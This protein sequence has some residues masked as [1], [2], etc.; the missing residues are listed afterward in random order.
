[1]VLMESKFCPRCGYNFT[2]T[3]PRKKKLVVKLHNK[4]CKGE[5]MSVEEQLSL[6]LDN[7]TS[8]IFNSKDY[9]EIVMAGEND[10]IKDVLDKR[11]K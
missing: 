7:F 4:K 2:M 10:T 3:C 11:R 6:H 8:T 9:R 1:M 5:G